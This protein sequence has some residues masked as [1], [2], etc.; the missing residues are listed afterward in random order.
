MSLRMITGRI[1]TRKTTIVHEEI[2]E[3]LDITESTSKSQL[4]KARRLL[5]EKLNEQSILGYGTH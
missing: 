5:Q 4:F 1:G 3:M 2:A